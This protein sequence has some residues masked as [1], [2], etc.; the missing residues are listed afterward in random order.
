MACRCNPNGTFYWGLLNFYI[1]IS[2]ESFTYC[3]STPLDN[4]YCFRVYVLDDYFGHLFRVFIA[5]SGSF[6]QSNELFLL[7]LT[8]LYLTNMYLTVLKFVPY[9]D[10]NLAFSSI[11]TI[12]SDCHPNVFRLYSNHICSILSI[13]RQFI[14]ILTIFRLC[15][16][17]ISAVFKPTFSSILT[18]I[19]LRWQCKN[20]I[21]TR[22]SQ[23]ISGEK[24]RFMAPWGVLTWFS[25]PL[26]KLGDTWKRKQVKKTR[27]WSNNIFKERT[28]ISLYPGE[29]HRKHKFNSFNLD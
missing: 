10:C 19:A 18:S 25:P 23:W 28:Q 27:P 14:S 17:C 20:R 22:L 6:L 11:L 9:F 7:H 24:G 13:F 4:F 3:I 12:Y 21:W 29:R 5:V 15:S 8:W 2:C 26:D 16:E 1:S